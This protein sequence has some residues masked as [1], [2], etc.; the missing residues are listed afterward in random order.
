[1]FYEW[2]PVAEVLMDNARAFR[3][4]EIGALFE[5]WVVTA[6]YMAAHRSSGN[7]IVERSHRTIKA[8]AEQSGKSPIDAAFWYNVAPRRGQHGD[9]IPQ[10]SVN[11]Y[12]W[13]LPCVKAVLPRERGDSATLKLGRK[14]TTQWDRGYVSGINSRQNVK[15]DGMPR[16]I[17]DVRPV[18]HEEPPLVGEKMR[19]WNSVTC[20]RRDGR[21]SGWATTFQSSSVNFIFM[22]IV[23]I[24]RCSWGQI[25]LVM[26][27]FFFRCMENGFV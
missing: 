26:F 15:V 13:R 19:S 3:S 20:S 21:L 23:Q 2:G 7:G 4:Q 6:F 10:K 12:T 8:M 14:Y 18:V 5:K 24:S 25:M 11:S 22:Y 17:L 9:L 1:M 16:H 27:F